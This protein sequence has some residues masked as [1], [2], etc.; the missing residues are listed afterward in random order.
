MTISTLDGCLGKITFITLQPI[1][2]WFIHEPNLCIVHKV[3]EECIDELDI[4]EH[5]YC[6]LCEHKQ[7]IF[8]CSNCRNDFCMWLFSEENEGANCKVFCHNFK[9]YDSYSIVSCLYENTILPEVIMNRSKFM[10]IV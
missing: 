1:V 7:R 3:C 6:S 9:G 8:S 4:D 5:S 2:V 10:S